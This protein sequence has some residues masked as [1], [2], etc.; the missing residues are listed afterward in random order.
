MEINGRNYPAGFMLNPLILRE[1]NELM[2]EKN[3]DY[4]TAILAMFAWLH[5]KAEDKRHFI[6]M[7]DVFQSSLINVAVWSGFEG[8]EIDSRGEGSITSRIFP[9]SEEL[10]AGI[11]LAIHVAVTGCV[12]FEMP[13]TVH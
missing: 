6:D 7:D 4:D 10:E 9:R 11:A 1:V 12:P 5:R 13:E 3:V 8:I 2:T